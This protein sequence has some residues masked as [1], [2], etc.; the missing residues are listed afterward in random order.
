MS[1]PQFSYAAEA[2]DRDNDEDAVQVLLCGTSNE[3]TI[4]DF[5]REHQRFPLVS[6]SAAAPAPAAFSAGDVLASSFHGG[7][8]ESSLLE[9]EG[10]AS[11][12]PQTTPP[13]R[14]PEADG[15]HGENIEGILDYSDEAAG[16]M[17][18]SLLSSFSASGAFPLAPPPPSAP[19]PAGLGAHLREGEGSSLLSSSLPRL[20]SAP[21]AGVPDV[22]A[23]TA[24]GK[25]VMDWEVT[26]DRKWLY[27]RDK[28]QWFNYGFDEATFKEWVQKL[29]DERRER[30]AHRSVVDAGEEAQPAFASQAG[31]SLPYPAAQTFAY[32]APPDSTFQR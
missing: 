31:Y 5:A 12:Q 15:A 6:L 8:E 21:Q 20:A 17:P 16:A 2:A 22:A 4:T 11:L 13:P 30:L 25:V 1:A 29:L 7:V 26:R 18:A 9:A 10:D 14:K 27:A 3:G 19:E 32:Q 24:D 23:A 28:A